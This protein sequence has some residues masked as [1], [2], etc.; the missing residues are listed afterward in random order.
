MVARDLPVFQE[1]GGE[2]VTYFSGDNPRDL[3]DCLEHWFGALAEGTAPRSGKIPWMT[4]DESAGQFMEALKR[5][6]SRRLSDRPL[7][8]R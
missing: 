5:N 6:I 3:A 2:N 1:V 7:V 8:A 4:W